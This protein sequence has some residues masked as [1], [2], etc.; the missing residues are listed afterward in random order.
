MYYTH[1]S[2]QE[3][4]AGFWWKPSSPWQNHPSGVNKLAFWFLGNSNISIQMYGPAPYFL[5]VVTE[6]PAETKRYVPNSTATAVTLGVWHRVEWHMSTTGLVEWW[7][8]GV[9]QGR[10]TGIQY[11][12]TSGFSMFQFSPTWGGVD[13]SKGEA[14]H[15][16]YNAVHLSG[17]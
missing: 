17:R 3:V 2:R 13:G 5:H 9:L 14:D 11:S 8:D 10:Y 6:L 15:Y 16:W 7:L 1:A 12:S 4:Y